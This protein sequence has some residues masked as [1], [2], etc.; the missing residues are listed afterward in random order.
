MNSSEARTE[1]STPLRSGAG[2]E[3]SPAARRIRDK[4]AGKQETENWRSSRRR[5]ERERKG[6]EKK[7]SQD[8]FRTHAPQRNVIEVTGPV[9]TSVAAACRPS[10]MFVGPRILK[11]MSSSA[12]RAGPAVAV[13]A[14]TVLSP[15]RRPAGLADAE[16]W[17]MPMI[18]L[19]CCERKI[20]FYEK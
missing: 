10:A 17:L 3:C 12:G 20:L 2:R 18:T 19:K 8:A 1:H 11:G 6:E 15:L 14:V 4:L 16:I 9:L 7:G 13:A 5:C